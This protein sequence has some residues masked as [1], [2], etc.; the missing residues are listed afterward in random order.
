[1]KN[2][3][4]NKKELII[5]PDEATII[6]EDYINEINTNTK[7]SLDI[8]P[9]NIYNMLEEQKN[10]IKFYIEYKDVKLAS[11]LANIDENKAIDYLSAYSSQQEIRRIYKALM[12][13]RFA[14]KIISLDKI[15]AYLST[16]LTDEFI[17]EGEKLNSKDKLKCVNLLLDYYKLKSEFIT[18]P[19]E[20]L[21]EKDLEEDIKSLSIDTIKS[22]L[23]TKNEN[24]NKNSIVDKISKDNKLSI[25]EEA[26]LKTLSFKE[27]SDLLESIK[28]EGD[29]IE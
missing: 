15:G 26:Y 24:D 12:H 21:T 10:F 5:N 9:L 29:D 14:S 18:N 11:V 25:E 20:I 7:Y 13:R 6:S 17:P 3:K 1:M 16:L 4:K 23:N 22:L 19:K 27:L 28:K 8:D 2:I